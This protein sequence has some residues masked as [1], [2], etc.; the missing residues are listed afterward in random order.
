MKIAENIQRMPAPKGRNICSTGRKP[1][2]KRMAFIQASQVLSQLEAECYM[3][4][5]A[6]STLEADSNI[7][8]KT[9]K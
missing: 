2:V 9:M 3:R 7:G 8:Y 5:K 1:C 6:D 4:R